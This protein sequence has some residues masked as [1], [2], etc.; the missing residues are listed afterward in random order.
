ML[1][2]DKFAVKEQV[3]FLKNHKT[4]DIFDPESKAQIGTAEETISGL[5]KM[6]RW[7]IDAKFMGTKIEVREYPEKALVFTIRRGA[8]FF[9]SRV[10]VLD[11]NGDLVGYFKSKFF[12]LGGGFHVYDKND[13]HFAEVKGNFTGFKYRVLTPDHKVELGRVSKEWGGLM[14]ELFTSA[15]SY[16]VD[17]ADDLREQPIAKMLVLATCLATDMIFKSEQKGGVGGIDLGE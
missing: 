4:Y 3:K 6:L 1:S 7:V 12:S 15:D 5:V 17:V 8:Y 11:G 2:A 13:K 9:R 14:K 16:I 10:E